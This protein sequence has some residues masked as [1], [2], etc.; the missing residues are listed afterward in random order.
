MD[1]LVY[2][3]GR[4]KEPIGNLTVGETQLNLIQDLELTS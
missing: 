4:D 2:G 3:V 1:M